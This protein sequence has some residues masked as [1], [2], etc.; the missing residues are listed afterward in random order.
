VSNFGEYAF[1]LNPK[2]GASSWPVELQSSTSLRYTCRNPALTRLT[3]TVWYSTN[4][5]AWQR[6]SGASQSVFATHGDVET[7]D[8][9]P[10]P[11]L[12]SA[13]RLFFQIR[14]D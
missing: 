1:G 9:S 13:P 8:V 7:I 4:L 5:N 10:S 3:Y 14:A 11:G 6:D 12:L 2:S